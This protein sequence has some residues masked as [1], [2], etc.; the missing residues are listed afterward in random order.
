MKLKIIELTDDGWFR[1]LPIEDP[2]GLLKLYRAVRGDIFLDLDVCK[3]TDERSFGEFDE[4]K[5]IE[6]DDMQPHHFLAHG[7]RRVEK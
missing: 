4:G 1:C 6:I 3:P 7:A 5:I 2:Q